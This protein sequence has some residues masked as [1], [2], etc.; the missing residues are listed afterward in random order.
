MRTFNL[1]DEP[2]VP[3]LYSDAHP[4]VVRRVGLRQLFDDAHE[5]RDLALPPLE[6][7]AVMRLLI[8]ITQAALRGPQDESA[9]ATCLPDIVPKVKAYLQS[10][11]D[12]FDLFGQRPFL[13][14]AA[15]QPTA[16]KTDED[17][18][19]LDKLN[20]AWASGNAHT[21]FDHAALGGRR[22]ISTPELA[23]FLLT[24]QCFHPGGLLGFA[25]W[26]GK[27]TVRSTS[28]APCIEGSPLLALL[29]GDT[30]LQTIH[31]NL[32]PQSRLEYQPLGK[33]I[34]EF[35]A[36]PFPDSE[37]ASQVTNSY[38]GRLV[39]LARAIK[40]LPDSS[41][42]LLTKGLEYPKFPASR[43]PMATVV[44]RS[45]GKT[46]GY[47]GVSPDKHPWR[48]L[49]SVLLLGKIQE[50]GGPLCLHNLLSALSEDRTVDLWVGGMTAD[51]AKIIDA[52]EWLFSFRTN[53]LTESALAIYREGVEFANKQEE[54]LRAA[55]RYYC[56]QLALESRSLTSKASP[57]YWS[58]LDG[59]Y[60]ELIN[61]A[62]SSATLDSW[63]RRC[64]S[65]AR[66]VYASTCPAQTPRQIQAFVKAQALVFATQKKGAAA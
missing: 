5:I 55:V 6:R 56:N 65:V 48:D 35:P 39:P 30:L 18:A 32:I 59:Y 25:L 41:R 2:W 46:L 15:L 16:G 22:E 31:W 52:R 1:I 47:L 24:F 34:W 53:I 43:E 17:L 19:P 38:L 3:V 29:I 27:Q 10:H 50:L 49:H 54:A 57:L 45:D 61:I 11:H 13:Q 66:E 12:C 4:G 26:D 28:Q 64:R 8:C 40:L 36:P 37:E 60:P 51:Q 14:V 33:P 23:L 7:V 20:F 9:W 63:E 62:Q 58:L 21:L 42:C 44:L